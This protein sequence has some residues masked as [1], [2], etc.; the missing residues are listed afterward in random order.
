MNDLPVMETGITV[1]PHHFMDI[2]KLYGSGIRVFVPDQ[3]MNHDFYRIANAVVENPRTQLH[4]T[5]EA[6][7]ICVPCVK[8]QMHE[9]IDTL[10]QIPGFQ[11]KN[12]YNRTLD[13]RLIKELSLDIHKAYEAQELCNIMWKHHDVIYKVWKE[14]NDAITER[15]HDLFVKG[16]KEYLS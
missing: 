12:E 1:K 9:C 2:I 7:D 3:K 10:D 6:D 5:I 14:E 15:R 11:T 4:L 16:A 13:S 8:C